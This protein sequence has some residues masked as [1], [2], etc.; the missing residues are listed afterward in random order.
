MSEQLA[1][2]AITVEQALVFVYSD[3]DTNELIAEVEDELA[4]MSRTLDKLIATYA[5]VEAP[6]MTLSQAGALGMALISEEG[7]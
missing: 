6:S 3:I 7:E 1:G 2:F 5:P 4:F